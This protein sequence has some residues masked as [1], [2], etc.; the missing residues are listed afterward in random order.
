MLQRVL[1]TGCLTLLLAVSQVSIGSPQAWEY[2]IM[3]QREGTG[4]LQEMEARINQLGAQGWELVAVTRHSSFV[5]LFFKR[6]K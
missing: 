3:S 1:R 6:A 5:T 4:Y 2:K